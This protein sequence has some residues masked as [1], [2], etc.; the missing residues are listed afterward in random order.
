MTRLPVPGNCFTVRAFREHHERQGSVLGHGLLQA[1]RQHDD[2]EFVAVEARRDRNNL[3][4]E[5][6]FIRP[7]VPQGLT[8]RA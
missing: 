6:A 1:L 3:V 5:L 7:G 4:C 2:V 8:V